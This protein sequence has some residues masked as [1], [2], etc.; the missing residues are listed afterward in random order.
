MG[1]SD[2]NIFGSLRRRRECWVPTWRGCLLLASI[3]LAT[4]AIGL[5]GVYPFL[6]PVHPLNADM[7]VV[8]GW[9]D[10]F[11]LEAA[12][13]ELARGKYSRLLV[14]G[15]PIERGDRLFAY[16][17]Y[18][19]LGAASL[20]Q[21]GTPTNLVRAI[22]APGVQRDRTYTSALA[23]RQWLREPG[24]PTARI[25]IVTSASHARRTRLL[26]EKALGPE[27]EVGIIA[28]RDPNYDPDRWWSR[29]QGFREVVSELI[30]Y[31]YARLFFYPPAPE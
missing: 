4:L 14:T 13:T 24:T 18:A 2:R 28:V 1:K 25:N 10:D 22:P 15:G 16:H 3:G 31:F 26:F 12:Q 17:T 30:A 23:L 7:L 11:I 9:G 29:S 20:V 8:E 21:M 19:E 27:T 5:R 6:A